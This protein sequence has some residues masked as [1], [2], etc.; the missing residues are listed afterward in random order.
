MQLGIVVARFEGHGVVLVVA[1][2]AIWTIVIIKQSITGGDSAVLHVIG[3]PDVD[4]IAL[5]DAFGLAIGIDDGQSDAE[6][7]NFVIGDVG[8]IFSLLSV[9]N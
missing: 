1:V 5:C 7:A 9:A 3:F 8:R 2:V 6:I 4:V